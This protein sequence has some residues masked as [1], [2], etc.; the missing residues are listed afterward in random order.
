MVEGLGFVVLAGAELAHLSTQRLVMGLTSTAFFALLGAALG[1]AAWGLV[2][3]R[4]WSRSP[5][6]AV[7]VILLGTAWSFRGGETSWVWIG[8][9]AIALAVI[10]L[11]LVRPSRDALAAA[12]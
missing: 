2:T 11:I 9:S 10:V 6:I 5:V 12:V 4:S 1:L 7:Q 8:A 3:C